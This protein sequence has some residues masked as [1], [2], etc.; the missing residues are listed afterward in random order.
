MFATDLIRRLKN[1]WH[2]FRDPYGYQKAKA[3]TEIMDEDVDAALLAVLALGKPMYLPTN[4]VSVEVQREQFERW[5]DA[6]K[7]RLREELAHARACAALGIQ[8]YL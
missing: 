7:E 2:A 6:Q 3:M 1:A 8:P 4:M 5:S